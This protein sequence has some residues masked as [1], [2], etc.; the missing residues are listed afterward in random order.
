MAAVLSLGESDHR[1]SDD[2]LLLFY[3]KSPDVFLIRS[4]WQNVFFI[5]TVKSLS[6]FLTRGSFI[7]PLRSV[8]SV[9]IIECI[10]VVLFLFL[11]LH[12]PH[13]V[14][15]KTENTEVST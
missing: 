7:D 5:W 3:I 15:I 10:Q 13:I 8:S 14:V 11:E 4:L 6:I 9:N 2:G 12:P 1:A